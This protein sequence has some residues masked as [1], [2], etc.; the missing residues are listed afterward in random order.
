VTGVQ[1]CALPISAL[2]AADHAES[3][4]ATDDA[5]R[6]LRVALDLLP[7]GDERR[8]RLLARLGLALAWALR[9][10][11]AVTVA[12]E[13]AEAIAAA[14]GPDA[15]VGYLA[16]ATF[17]CGQAGGQPQAWAMATRGLEYR[18]TRRDVA[19][20]LLVSFEDERRA[21][22]D[23]EYPGVP[24][25][26]AERL[27]SA[28]ILREADLDPMAPAVM[29][30]P[31]R[32]RAE[33]LTARNLPLQIMNCGRFAEALVDL[34]VEADAALRRG[35][36]FRA[37]RCLSFGALCSAMLGFPD[38]V[39]H[40]LAE[41]RA[42]GA[43][44]GRPNPVEIFAMEEL[45]LF[46]D[47]GADDLRSLVAGLLAADPPALRWARGYFLAWSARLAAVG[48]DPDDAMGH[49]AKLVA[50]VE[51]APAWTAGMS[52]I[53]SYCAEVLWILDRTD[54]ADRIEAVVLHKHVEPDFRGPGADARLSM[55]RLCVL[56][57]R[58]DEARTWFAAARAVLTEQGAR[59]L[60]AVADLDEA[61]VLIRFGAGDGADRA[62]ALLD[63]AR[64][65][66]EELGMTGWLRRAEELEKEG[67]SP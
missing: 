7:G 62:R 39:R 30:A 53:A 22:A 8:P 11:D 12:A 15:A 10:D 41:S 46:W 3:T 14:D 31:S 42:L 63:S 48:G 67:G 61:R 6:F 60:L 19:W 26:T 55:A 47:E 27:E 51:K 37:A 49:L 16:E 58:P 36:L 54:Y 59:P 44:V 43:R 38:D 1:T 34:Q 20:A 50:W 33:V 65:Q 57:G 66:F 28:R 35:Q 2:A 52:I 13:A 5:T 4:G 32:S 17:T 24:A 23:E 9:F 18:T 29:V 56:T 21:A 45:A 25:E 64:R 40:A